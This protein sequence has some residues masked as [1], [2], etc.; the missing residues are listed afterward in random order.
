MADETKRDGYI[1]EGD[2]DVA[3]I[4]GRGYGRE[5]RVYGFQIVWERGGGGASG[6]SL[7]TLSI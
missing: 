7:K 4:E 2:R 5:V 3:N 6:G 1:R